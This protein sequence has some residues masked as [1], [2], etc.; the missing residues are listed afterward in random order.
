[1]TTAYYERGELHREGMLPAVQTFDLEGHLTSQSFWERGV[2]L[3]AHGC[4]STTP[5][6]HRRSLRR[7]GMLPASLMAVA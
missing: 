6:V 4:H 3:K 5:L 7:E 2:M 1:M